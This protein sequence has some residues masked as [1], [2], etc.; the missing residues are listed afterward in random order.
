MDEILTDFHFV[1]RDS[2]GLVSAFDSEE[3]VAVLPSAL[4]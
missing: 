4:I 1:D 2:D 3:T